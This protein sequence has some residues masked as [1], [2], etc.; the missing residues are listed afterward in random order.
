MGGKS[1]KKATIV[2]DNLYNQDMLELGLGMCEGTIEGLDQG[3]RSL[4]VNNIPVESELGEYNFQDIGINFRQGYY[5]DL[6]VKY[7]MG[8]ESSVLTNSLG[9]SLPADVPRTI[10]TGPQFRG[11]IKGLD[12]RIIIS[13]LYAGDGQNTNESSVLFQVKYR[14]VG[15]TNWS[16]VTATTASLSD[17]KRKVATLRQEAEKEGIDW[18]SLSPEDRFEF[19]LQTL[20]QI[21]NITSEDLENLD[22]APPTTPGSEAVIIPGFDRARVFKNRYYRT[23]AQLYASQISGVTSTQIYNEMI[24]VHG[25]T[26]SGTVYELNI[27]IFDAEGDQHDW[28]IQVVR[29]SREL[30]AEEKKFSGKVIGLDSIVVITETEKKYTKTAIC[31]IVAQHTDR[32]SDIPDFSADIKGFICD[33]PTNYNPIA[34]SW[35]GV[36]DG[37]F[38]KGWTDNN[39]LIAHEF[40]MNRDWGKRASEPQLKVDPVTLMEAIK[41]CDEKVPDLKGELKPRHTFNDAI[42]AERDIDEYLKYILGSFH[43]TSREIFGVY[44][45][46]IDRKKEPNF[47]VTKETALQTGISYYRSD[48]TSR[49]N[50]MRVSF[51]NKENN[52]EED[53]RVLVDDAAQ[54]RD[55]II[56]FSFQAIGATNLSEAVR[57]GVYLMYTN[58]E[59]TTFASFS[60]PRLGHVVNLYDHFYIADA[61]M[62]WGASARILDYDKLTGTITLRDPLVLMSE[63]ETF[64]VYVHTHFGIEKFIA[65]TNNPYLLTVSNSANFEEYALYLV[66]NAP[67]MLANPVYGEPKEFRI[68]SIEQSDSND[69]AQGELFAFKSAIVSDLKYQ[70]IDNIND[71]ELVDFTFN[72]VDQTYNRKKI[73]TVPRNVSLWMHDVLNDVGQFTYGLQFEASKNA[74]RYEVSWVNKNTQEKRETVIYGSQAT[75]APAF[76]EYTPLKL[77]IVPYNVDDEPGDV[78]YMDDVILS[79]PKTLGLPNLISIVYLSDTKMLRFNFTAANFEAIPNSTT[80]YTQ[81]TYDYI[82]PGRSGWN[83][84]GDIQAAYVDIPY[85]GAGTYRLM[86]KYIAPPEANNGQESS[87]IVPP[88]VY[89]GDDSGS[90]PVNKYPKPKLI[91]ISST[92]TS[93]FNQPEAPAGFVYTTLNLKFPNIADYPEMLSRFNAY[94]FFPFVILYSENN[95][96]VYR[97]LGYFSGG[98]VVYNTSPLDGLFKINLHS[99]WASNELNFLGPDSVKV[100]GKIR[101][102]IADQNSMAGMPEPPDWFVNALD[103]DW[104]EVTVPPIGT[105]SYDPVAVYDENKQ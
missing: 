79:Y 25:K 26:S 19:E 73:A 6:P 74:A 13:Q 71:P 22:M 76:P 24:A 83:M 66:E 82:A 16:Y 57:Q 1:G 48:L 55:G 84:T 99:D 49:F 93:S 91:S 34:K 30:Y 72:S 4:F 90:L 104:L 95:D 45:F 87:L 50:M 68:L 100:G 21:Q 11:K 94:S 58:K 51:K 81:M 54:L 63:Y 29:R 64:T 27:P 75:L 5:D 42:S 103:S 31:Q 41:Y 97:R 88:W 9:L 14:K 86:L 39:A 62:D 77:K 15:A 18:D 96:G 52:F 38:K 32:F 2:A 3:L 28:E 35:V 20:K 17:Y 89:F 101:I 23:L 8:G 60:Q 40:I 43:A 56:P 47:F 70:A 105:I 102:K 80:N 85:L 61:D 59:E 98:G 12:V 78:L 46:F 69:V 36:W 7:L 37:Y 44:R 33:I 10:I 67:I 92:K 65:T 53:R